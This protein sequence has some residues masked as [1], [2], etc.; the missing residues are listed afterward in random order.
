MARF[1]VSFILALQTALVLGAPSLSLL[2]FVDPTL[3]GG[4]LLDDAGGGL[5]EPLNVSLHFTTPQEYMKSKLS[6]ELLSQVII[7]GWSSAGV[8]TDDGFTN[9]A[10]AAGMYIRSSTYFV[11]C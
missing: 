11:A 10:R 1:A 3:L 4:S 5:G 2:P 9:F 7:S 6:L 8:L